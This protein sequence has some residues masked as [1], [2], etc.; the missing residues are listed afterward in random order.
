MMPTKRTYSL[1]NAS[2]AHDAPVLSPHERMLEAIGLDSDLVEAIVGDLA[3]EFALR[4]ARD[5][6]GGARLWY[7]REVL[8][9]APHLIES[10]LRR[11][12]PRARIR[13]AAFLTGILLAITASVAAVLLRNGPPARLVANFA[14]AANG[15]VVNN[16]GPVQLPVRVL[17]RRGHPLESRDVSYRWTAGA[18]IAVS[19]QGVVSCAQRGNATVRA[20]LGAITTELDVH[21]RPVKTLQASS[22]IDLI[23]GQVQRDLPFT[24][25]GAR[26]ATGDAAAWRDTHRGQHRCGTSG[27]YNS[28]AS[29]RRDHGYRGHRRPNGAHARD[30][31]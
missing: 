31:S 10:A 2:R 19:P 24:A 13:L 12:E 17:D 18:P 21:C 3:E 30:R 26:R 4:T 7:I 15:I 8:R 6:R 28:S 1:D 5:G 25:L 27:N 22:W 20:S 29:G 14:D 9:S 16:I 11:G 23:P